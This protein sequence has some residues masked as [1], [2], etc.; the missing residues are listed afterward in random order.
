VTLPLRVA[1]DQCLRHASLMKSAL[2]DLP[3]PLDAGALAADEDFLI[4]A[5]DQFVLRFIKLQDTLGEHV[6]RAFASEVLA[7]PV[8][9]LPMIDVLARL[10]AL[11]FSRFGAVGTVACPAELAH[12]RV[13]WASGDED[14]CA[15]GSPRRCGRAGQ[16][17]GATRLTAR[18]SAL[19]EHCALD[20]VVEPVRVQGLPL[21]QAQV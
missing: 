20:L 8:S 1:L 17:G 2:A 12:T 16:V 13:P 21:K 9:D 7:E 15:G 14:R 19:I 10:G 3:N 18:T 11:R 6:L 4:R 5:I